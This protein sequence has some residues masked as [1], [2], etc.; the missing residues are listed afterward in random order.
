MF[1]GLPNHCEMIVW[2]KTVGNPF[3]IK[4]LVRQFS[5]ELLREIRG[6]KSPSVRMC[7]IQHF[8][9][10]RNIEGR[11]VNGRR[12]VMIEMLSIYRLW[13]LRDVFI[14]KPPINLYT[15]SLSVTHSLN[16]RLIHGLTRSLTLPQDVTSSRSENTEPVSAV[17]YA[18]SILASIS[19]PHSNWHNF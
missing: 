1:S 9:V 16:Y 11:K 7:V 19:S 17:L 8:E 6:K 12:R 13:E 18:S 15:A 10:T 2:K 4:N 14:V 3:E 5:E